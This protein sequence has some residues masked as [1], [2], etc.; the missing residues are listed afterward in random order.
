VSL[1]PCDIHGKDSEHR[2]TCVQCIEL[3]NSRTEEW[4][5]RAAHYKTALEELKSFIGH[6]GQ[7]ALH[8][9]GDTWMVE[10]IMKA[11]RGPDAR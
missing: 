4:K 11:L 8:E 7:D 6:A 5:R 3:I 9:P 1:K 2:V 10:R